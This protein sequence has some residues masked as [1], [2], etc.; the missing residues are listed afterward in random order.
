MDTYNEIDFEKWQMAIGK[1]IM[2][3]SRVEFE[4]L[5]F[6]QLRLPERS[7][8]E[9]SYLDRFDKAI[10]VSKKMFEPEI[11]ITQGL[12]EIRKIAIYTHMVAHNPVHYSSETDNW[13]IFNLK[14]GK[15]S[16]TLNDLVSISNDAE[17]LSIRVAGA[18]R[19]HS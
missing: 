1:L 11:G 16:V 2:A 9:D 13:C 5:R 7:Y 18:L 8:L 15:I 4:L 10:G 17:V 6:Y 12:I 3:C 19:I 14:N